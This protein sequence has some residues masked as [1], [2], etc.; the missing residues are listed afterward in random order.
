[1]SYIVGNNNYSGEVSPLFC[2]LNYLQALNLA[3]NSLSGML[4]RCLGKSSSL[5]MLALTYNSFHGDIPPFCAN[6]NSLKIVGLSYNRLQGK[7]P[8]S[9]ADCTQL[10]FLDIGNNQMSDIFPSW[11]G[12]LPVLRGLI[13]G[14]N[15]FH[16]II[17]KP[18]TNHEFPN[19]CIIDL[20]NNL[21]SGMLPSKYMENW[22]F[23]KYVVANE[24][25]Q[26]FLVPSNSSI[27]KYGNYYEFSYSIIIPVKGVKLTYYRTP[28]DLRLIDFS[29]NRFEGEIP[30]SIIG[31]L[32]ELHFLNLS[33][34][35][36]S[37]HIPSSLGNLTALE[38]FNVSHNHLWGQIPL[39]Q[40][41]GTFLEDSYQGNSGLCGKPLSKKCEGTESSR[42]PPP[43]SFEEDEEA[44]FTFEFDWYVVL[45]GV[46]SGLVVGVVAGNTLADK[47][48][49][50]FV[51]TFR[52]KRKST[53]ARVTRGRRT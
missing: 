2:N 43:S 12:V 16:G 4:P 6:R 47:K 18:P 45:P 9:M 30:A 49:E 53:T 15:A 36:L 13:L 39:G 34:N 7:L 14:S 29:S 51:E 21:F 27:N 41:F 26:Y 44:G 46:V 20:S 37:G 48:H 8:R 50:W 23:M 33:N 5:E 1:M 42:L 32:R 28:Y 31:S 24:G 11:L 40:Q 38:Y 19:L 10:E 17:G 22:N 52:R 35:A 25:S 3:N